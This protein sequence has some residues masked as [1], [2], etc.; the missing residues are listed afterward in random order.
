MPVKTRGKQ[1]KNRKMALKDTIMPSAVFPPPKAKKAK[2]TLRQVEKI[3]IT[4]NQAEKAASAKPETFKAIA[5]EV[6]RPARKRFPTRRVIVNGPNEIWASDLVQMTT[7]TPHNDGYS[8]MLNVIDIFTRY[9]WCVALKQKTATEVLEGF[10]L[11]AK[12]N[13]GKTPRFLWTDEGKEYYNKELKGWCKKNGV[14]LYSTHGPHKSAMVERFNRTIKTY[15]W[16]IFIAKNTRKWIN[17]VPELIDFYNNKP[18][19]GIKNMTPAEAHNLK[20]DDVSDLWEYQYDDL[21]VKNPRPPKFKVGDYVRMSRKKGIF[22][23]GFEP[24][25]TFEIYK[26]TEVV[27]SVPWMYKVEDLLG[28]PFAGSF[29]EEELQ[30]TKQTPKSEFMAEKVL[31]KKTVDGKKMGLVKW[32]GFPAKFNSWEEITS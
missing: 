25:W 28:E 32:L 6:T 19:R 24:S 2:L 21:P 31:Q 1:A 22:E 11:I 12:N 20:Q 15:M 4:Q 30:K 16:K 10:K 14:T 27:K 9:A 23:K 7:F 13:G 3:K 5:D 29:Y 18:H 17:L 26:I 8:Y